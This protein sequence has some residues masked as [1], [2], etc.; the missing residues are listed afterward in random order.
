MIRTI[1]SDANWTNDVKMI[2]I[3]AIVCITL[4]GVLISFMMNGTK[5]NDTQ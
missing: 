5:K 1:I 3:F 4:V 2:A